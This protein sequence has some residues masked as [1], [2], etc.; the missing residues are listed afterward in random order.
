M[1]WVLSYRLKIPFVWK[2]P[3]KVKQNLVSDF[4][5]LFLGISI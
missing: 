5:A 3:K 2:Q 1:G 4:P